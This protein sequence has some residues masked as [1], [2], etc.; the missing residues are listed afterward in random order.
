MKTIGEIGPNLKL[1]YLDSQPDKKL[2]VKKITLPHNSDINQL[3]MQQDAVLR[4]V[5]ASPIY[6]LK[7]EYY[8]L[9]GNSIF[10]CTPV[11]HM[12]LQSLLWMHRKEKRTI[13]KETVRQFA[14]RAKIW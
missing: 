4:K 9:K 11:Q 2:I 5:S 3:M 10:L 14:V 6:Y 1:A 7:P 13:S 12:S 8:E